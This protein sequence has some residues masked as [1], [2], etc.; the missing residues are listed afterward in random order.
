[1][2]APVISAVQNLASSSLNRG[3]RRRCALSSMYTEWRVFLQGGNNGW[4]LQGKRSFLTD[5]CPSENRCVSGER[6]KKTSRADERRPHGRTKKSVIEQKLNWLFLQITQKKKPIS[7]LSL[8]LSLIFTCRYF[9]K[10]GPTFISPFNALK[11][12]QTFLSSLRQNI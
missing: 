6:R 7:T 9:I 8:P 10:K 11:P 4:L 3:R 5:I 2:Y 12:T 1:M